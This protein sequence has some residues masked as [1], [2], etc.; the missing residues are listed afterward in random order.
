MSVTRE[1]LLTI[2][3]P[4]LQD[5]DKSFK[6]IMEEIGE[7]NLLVN[8]H[9]ALTCIRLFLCI[10]IV[11]LKP[12]WKKPPGKPK[13]YNIIEWHAV[14]SDKQKSAGD[15]LFCVWNGDNYCIPAIPTPIAK[16]NTNL[17]NVEEN[18]DGAKDLINEIKETGGANLGAKLSQIES[19]GPSTLSR[20]STRR[21]PP[22]KVKTHTVSVPPKD[23]DQDDNAQP[24]QLTYT[25][26]TTAMEQ[27]QCPCGLLFN[28]RED[29]N[30]H[31]A[32][33]KPS[34][35]NCYQCSKVYDSRG[36]FQYNCQECEYGIDERAQI[37]H[38]MF[39]K[40]GVEIEGIIKCPNE[41]CN[42]VAP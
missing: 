27:N 35:W 8:I 5:T 26:E 25:E 34:T 39:H 14:S 6:E 9:I 41:G 4:L 23:T 30:T 32:G 19:G 40:H 24:T 20:L 1:S 37:V 22:E 16:L 11:L 21:P 33:H 29:L 42:Y 7:C 36:V 15:K 28:S 38:H 3:S 13:Q 17:S 10:P 12:S 31:I 18:I 2:L